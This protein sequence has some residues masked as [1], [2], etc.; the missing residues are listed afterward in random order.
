MASSESRSTDIHF[1]NFLSGD[2]DSIVSLFNSQY[3]GLGGFVPRTVEYW[4]WC[5][6]QRP[7]VKIQGIQVAERG[8]R[9]VGYVVVGNSGNV[10]ELC[11]D[12]RLGGEGVVSYLI[13]YALHYVRSVGCDSIVLNA[14]SGDQIVRNVCRELGFAEA[15]SEPVFLSVLD[16]AELIRAILE[17]KISKTFRDQVFWFNL[18]NCPSWSIDSFGI[19]QRKN[20]VTILREPNDSSRVTVDVQMSTLV[21]IVFGAKSIFRALLSSEI[22]LDHFWN[23][24]K[25]IKFIRLLRTKSRWFIPRADMN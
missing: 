13:K 20:E 10:W 6:L 16:I 12:R 8:K 22:H 15:P 21:G 2:E 4:H 14:Y 3:E 5:C 1:R 7:D 17:A 11:C 19:S 23:L 9:I 24:P 25:T 18:K